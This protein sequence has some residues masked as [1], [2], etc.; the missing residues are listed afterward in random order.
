MSEPAVSVD[1]ASLPPARERMSAWKQASLSFYWL[2]TQIHWTAILMV[3][4]PKQA[5]SIGGTAH[6]GTA[7]GTI[8]LL[9]ALTSMVVAPLFGA[10]SD[11]VRT[12][13]GR[14]KPFL[15]LGT[16]GNVIGLIA[17]AFIPA[18]QESLVAYVVVFMWIE[19]FNNLATAP[20]S[21]LIPDVVP[22]EQRGSASGWMGLMSM[23]GIFIGGTTGLLLNTVGI[24]GIYLALAAVM[25][26]GMGGTVLAIREP[27]PPGIAPF[28]WGAFCRGLIEPFHSRDFTWVFFTR[29]LVT[30]G[31]FTVQVFM[32][33]YLRDVVAGG[34]EVFTYTFFG[35]PL[36]VGRQPVNSAEAA[37][38]IFLPA[39][40]TGAIISSLLAGVLSDRYGRK[41]MVYISGA[42]Q[43]LVCGIFIFSGRF[44]VALIVGMIFGLGYGAYQAVDWALASDV[45]PSKDDYAK[46]MG[47]WHVASTF[48]QVLAPLIAGKLLDIFQ[49]VGKAHG[50]PTLGYTVIFLV[51]FVYFIL[52]TILVS[53]IKGVR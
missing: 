20:Y 29:M 31:T 28:H 2:A 38:S 35:H 46:D 13:W 17:L 51:A 48:P 53:K 3:L 24:S 26:L 44:D 14:R 5:L 23:I 47:V 39:L 52:G 33:Y 45:L 25:L 41:R 18:R 1:M 34:H 42:L 6:K 11:R 50:L 37:M 8:L 43:A 7:L 27:E 4:L 32:L 9:G 21:A 19:L 12:R 15:V 22:A 40:L 10:W 16:L 36:V 49:G 30:L